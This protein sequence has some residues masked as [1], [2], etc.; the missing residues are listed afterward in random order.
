MF[1]T[2]SSRLEGP[3]WIINFPSKKH[4]RHPSKLEWIAEGLKD[5]T[6]V[7]SEKGIRSIALPPLGCGNGGLDWSD[8][9]PEIERQLGTLEGVEVV[10]F[11]PTEKYQNVAKSTGV[12]KLTPARA[13]IAEWFGGIGWLAV[14]ARTLKSRSWAGFWK[15]R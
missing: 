4:W 3:R 1:V 7:I 11:E 8:V 9:R 10:V 12:Q 14:A 2:E 13:M 6:R 15:E 5:L